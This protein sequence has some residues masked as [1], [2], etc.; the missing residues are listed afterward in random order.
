VLQYRLREWTHSRVR[1]FGTHSI[2]ELLIVCWHL[3]VHIGTTTSD[4]RHRDVLFFTSWVRQISGWVL[5]ESCRPV[6]LVDLVS[7]H[8]TWQVQGHIWVVQILSRDPFA[9]RFYEVQLVVFGLTKIS[10]IEGFLLF[11]ALLSSFLC[12]L[13]MFCQKVSLSVVHKNGADWSFSSI[14]FRVVSQLGVL[15]LLFF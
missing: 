14:D 13:H 11:Y 4:G 2:R 12:P 5:I 8:V 10:K 1:W 6:Q 15:S 9:S 7:R 3:S